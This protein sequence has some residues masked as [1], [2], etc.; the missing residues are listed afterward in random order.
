M[1]KFIIAVVL[2]STLV[3]IVAGWNEFNNNKNEVKKLETKVNT[4]AS[5]YPDI[6]NYINSVSYNNFDSFLKNNKDKNIL[7]YIGRPTCGDCTVFEPKLIQQITENKLQNRMVYLNVAKTR[8]NEK[9]WNIF[10]EKYHILY[11]PTLAIFKNGEPIK[12]VGWTPSEG[13]DMNEIEFFL[14]DKNNFDSIN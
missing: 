6:Y 7:V 12:K 9:E 2:L 8:K 4:L 13:V 10:K 11:T 1:K 14:K 3:I 5:S